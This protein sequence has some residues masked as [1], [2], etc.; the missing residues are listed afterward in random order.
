MEAD[1]MLDDLLTQLGYLG[2]SVGE[3]LKAVDPAHF[4]TIRDAWDAHMVRNK[5]AHSGESLQL[6]ARD[7]Q[8]A[9]NNYKRVFEEFAAI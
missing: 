1:I 5:I 8:T 7:V 9:I 4:K 2:T 3:K 6:E